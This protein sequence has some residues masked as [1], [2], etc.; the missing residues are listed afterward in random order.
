MFRLFVSHTHPNAAAVLDLKRAL[1]AYGIDAFVAHED[2]EHGLPWQAEI[3][4]AL[5]TCDGLLAYVTPDFSDSEWTDQE[6]GWCIGRR[7]PVMSIRMGADPYGFFGQFQAIRGDEPEKARAIV[8]ILL[9]DATQGPRVARAM[10]DRFVVSRNFAAAKE[11]VRILGVIPAPYWSD[12]MLDAVERACEENPQIRGAFYVP[13]T[14]RTIVSKAR[15]AQIAAR[16][17]P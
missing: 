9:R 10:V 4:S 7:V 17:T 6:V 2:I 1:A 3:E 12:E 13:G 16:G 5:A 15:E 11:N 14:A 8:T